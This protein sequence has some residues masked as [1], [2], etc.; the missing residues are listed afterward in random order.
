MQLLA[1]EVSAN[2]YTGPSE[3]LI[4]LVLTITCLQ[5]MDLH[6]RFNNHTTHSFTGSWLQQ[7]VSWV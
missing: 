2:Y 1:S 3:I 5:A 7:P 6:G 4:L